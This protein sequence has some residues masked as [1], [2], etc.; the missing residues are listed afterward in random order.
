MARK[1]VRSCA[2]SIALA[3]ECGVSAQVSNQ[4][5]S[6]QKKRESIDLQNECFASA[7][8][9]QARL[10]PNLAFAVAL[11]SQA[12][13][14]W[15]REPNRA[16]DLSTDLQSLAPVLHQSSAMVKHP[17]LKARLRSIS[18]KR[19]L[20]TELLNQIAARDPELAEKLARSLADSVESSKSGCGDNASTDCGSNTDVAAQAQP[21]L[22]AAKL[23]DAERCELLMSAALR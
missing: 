6:P 8:A 13:S 3:L 7:I 2:V 11:Q 19:Q 21:G 22:V 9:D 20:R 12:T 16:R 4:P 17:S 23:R 15:S 14:L 5:R 10:S 18:E 1:V